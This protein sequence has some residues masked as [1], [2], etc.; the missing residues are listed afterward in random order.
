MTP[1]CTGLCA[2]RAARAV[3]L[4]PLARNRPAARG[5]VSF[6]LKGAPAAAPTAALPAAVPSAAGRAPPLGHRA[7]VPRQRGVHTRVE[8]AY[9]KLVESGEIE[10]VPRQRELAARLG[11]L[12]VQWQA[13]A[14]G[15]GRA[16]RDFL[17]K[18]GLGGAAGAGA[19]GCGGMYIYGGVGVG[20]SLLMV[21]FYE[22]LPTARKRRAHF[23]SFML[24][25]HRRCHALTRVARHRGDVLAAVADLIAADVDVICFD[26]F[27]ETRVCVC[28]CACVRT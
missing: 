12:Q 24:D 16:W 15:A 26:E 5:A 9:A 10:D 17:R 3:L 7:G 2:A 23:H 28:V 13:G 4:A 20:K 14:S 19:A 18:T 27:Q 1:L 8:E 11:A 22:S 21:L 25:V 6:V